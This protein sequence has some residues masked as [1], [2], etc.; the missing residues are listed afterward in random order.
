MPAR[1]AGFTGSVERTTMKKSR[2]PIRFDGAA[3]LPRLNTSRRTRLS[4]IDCTPTYCSMA[5]NRPVF[6]Y[7]A[8]NRKD[9]LQ[10]SCISGGSIHAQW[11]LRFSHSRCVAAES[12]LQNSLHQAIFMT[13]PEGSE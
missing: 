5:A 11:I 13:I 4:M 12:E 3:M 1:V 7:I 9:Y 2:G 8:I 10:H 6:F